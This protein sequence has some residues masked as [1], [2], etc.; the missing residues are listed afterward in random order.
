[1]RLP[2]TDVI[3]DILRGRPQAIAWLASLKVDD[4]ALPGISIMELMQ[5]CQNRSDVQT[6]ES[7]IEG[8]GVAWP[9][10]DALQRALDDVATYHGSHGLGPMDAMIGE[11]AVG[12]EA[13]LCTFLLA[14]DSGG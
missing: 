4:F 3:I 8:L 13:N 5:G 9:D 6:V 12:M 1:M 11:T 14:Y 7:L 10:S 2:D